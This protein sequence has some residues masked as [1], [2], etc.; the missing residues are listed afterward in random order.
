MEHPIQMDDLGIPWIL[1]F[2]E[3]H[4]YHVRNSRNPIRNSAKELALLD[5]TRCG[6]ALWFTNLADP[7][8]SD[9]SLVKNWESWCCSYKVLRTIYYI[10]LYN[11]S[12]KHGRWFYACNVLHLSLLRYSS[13]LAVSIQIRWGE[14]WGNPAVVFLVIPS[15]TNIQ[16]TANSRAGKITVL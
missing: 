6:G 9:Q 5:Y 11:I 1:P 10:I 13:S 3:T 12:C 16:H 15:P 14:Q 8:G 7:F 2:Q 4:Q